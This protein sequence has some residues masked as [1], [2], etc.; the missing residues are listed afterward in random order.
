MRAYLV[1]AVL[2]A[3]LASQAAAQLAVGPIAIEN[4]VNG[5]PITVIATS[6][7]NVKFEDNE[8]VVSARILADLIDLQKKFPDVVG[9]FKP[10]ADNCANRTVD[11]PN[12]VVAIENGSLWPRADQLVI[13][14]R[15]HVDIWNCVVGP[16]KSEIKW[17]KK[18]IGFINMK[19]PVLHTWTNLKKNKNDTQPFDASLPVYFVRKDN[20]KI[21][22]EFAK[23]NIKLGGQY[24]DT[25]LKLADI[26]I[27]KKAYNALQS[28]IDPEKLK[29]ALPKELQKLNMPIISARFRDYG[30][31]AMAEINLAT[32]VSGTSTTQLLQQTSASPAD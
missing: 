25:V 9:T 31:H 29:A 7:I 20:E 8:L 3:V 2:S 13:F 32:R 16:S 28:A 18:K 12:P 30:G 26:D 21:A 17:Q 14:V 1:G 22:L 23:S 10:P 11:S 15:G 24:A 5:V 4:N 19:V 6:W 27:N